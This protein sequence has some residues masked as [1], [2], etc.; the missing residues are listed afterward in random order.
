MGDALY[1][2]KIVRT[3]KQGAIIPVTVVV[4]SIVLTVDN[5]RK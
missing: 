3:Y 1:T 5:Q 4:S 2:G